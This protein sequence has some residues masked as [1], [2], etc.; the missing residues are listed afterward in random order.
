M[1]LTPRETA[2]EE[3]AGRPWRPVWSPGHARPGLPPLTV[4][5]DQDD[6]HAFMAAALA[7]HTPAHGRITV[8][9][10]PVASAPAS[11]A[12]D[13]LRAVG[14]HLPADGS[15]EGAGWAAQAE[16][17]WRAVAAWMSVLRIGHL[18]I[19]RAHRISSRHV[20]H[21]LAL[22]EVTGMRLTLLCH[23]P[24]PDALATVLP[25]LA[26]EQVHT[27]A[28]TRHTLTA[29]GPYEPY[30]AG[31]AGRFA[32]WEAAAQYPPHLGEPCFWLPQR[33]GPSRAVLEAAAQRLGHP[34]LPLPAPGRFTPEPDERTLLLAHRLHARIA[35]PVHAAALA[36][37]V[38]T[39]RPTVQLQGPAA[40]AP[41]SRTPPGHPQE[42]P[43][44]SVDLL[45]AGRRFAALD[46][47]RTEGP[48]RLSEWDQQ[49]VAEAARACALHEVEAPGPRPERASTRPGRST[50]TTR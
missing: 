50:P 4:V 18:V 2:G 36:L 35:H 15:P 20:E 9:P 40:P 16:I 38:L 37:R 7:A 23:G 32:W 6:D 19:T 34:V 25:A 49:A 5:H 17:A 13:L 29:A 31:A 41:S 1:T 33:R 43:A 10:T 46:R 42:I 39:G 12:H 24:V 3:Q 30:G 45:A 22:R 21:L 44:W 11:L 26:H 14:K 28:A 27:L 47:I 8:H 48:L